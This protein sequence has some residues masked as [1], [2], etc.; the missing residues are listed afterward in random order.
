MHWRYYPILCLYNYFQN[1]CKVCWA[2][3]LDDMRIQIKPIMNQLES[4]TNKLEHKI[5]HFKVF[6][7][8]LSFV[9]FAV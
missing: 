6:L 2:Q 8:L 7:I 1:M 3:H 9:I 5:E 4:A